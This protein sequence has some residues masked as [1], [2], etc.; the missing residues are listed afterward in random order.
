MMD[1]K[2]YSKLMR[3]LTEA[4]LGLIIEAPEADRQNHIKTN[5]EIYKL[6]LE[7]GLASMEKK[8][9]KL[10]SLREKSKALVD[11]MQGDTVGKA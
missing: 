2:E 8:A 11:F 4:T 6:H 7:M 5:V 3:A 1:A 9:E 10:L